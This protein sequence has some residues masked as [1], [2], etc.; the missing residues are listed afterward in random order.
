MARR[1]W[2]AVAVV[3]VGALGMLGAGL[4]AKRSL[5]SPLEIPAEGLRLEVANGAS[6]RRVTSDLAE[7]GVLRQPWLLA[8]YGRWTGE[9]TRIRAGEYALSHGTTPVTLLAKLVSGEIY[10]HEITIV[11]GSRF[12]DALTAIRAHPAIASGDLDGASLMT[13]LGATGVHPEGQL[14]PD[15]YRFPKGTTDVEL[16]R[17]AH[18][19][20]VTRLDDAW[21]RRSPDIAIE[22]SYEALVL[23]SIIEKET[24]L[25]SER[26]L[27]SGVFQQRLRRNMRLQTDPTVIYGL[28][29]SY[30][31]NLRRRDLER[32]TPYNTYTRFGLPPTPIALV[33]VA[34]LEAAVAPAASDALFFVA[35][36]RG[37]GSHRFSAT[38]EEHERAVADYLR[39]LRSPGEQ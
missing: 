3:G 17:I 12:V 38:L 22:N 32:D 13:V 2:F 29:D 24:A 19:A 15:T 7:Q 16:L 30:D 35:T 5:N 26:P 11:E 28:G 23:A 10:L 20:L 8:S 37:D 9:A 21:N 39:Q 27:I 33:G 18:A 6:L 4:V 31:G 25:A 14:F 1:L 34:A 36:G